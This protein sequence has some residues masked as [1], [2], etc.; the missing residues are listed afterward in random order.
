MAHAEYEK[1]LKTVRSARRE[2]ALGIVMYNSGAP[3]D[4]GAVKVIVDNMMKTENTPINAIE[5]FKVLDAASAVRKSAEL[6][7]KAYDAESAEAGAELA[8]EAGHLIAH[9]IL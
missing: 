3:A 9:W 6:L 1:H 7:L 8:A 2:L 4:P 5:A